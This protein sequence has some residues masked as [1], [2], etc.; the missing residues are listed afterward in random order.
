MKKLNI[1][2][3]L[4]VLYMYIHFCGSR[5]LNTVMCTYKW[6][7]ERT[8]G[9]NF[10]CISLPR[11]ALH[12]KRMKNTFVTRHLYSNISYI[13]SLF[14]SNHLCFLSSRCLLPWVPKWFLEGPEMTNNNNTYYLDKL[15]GSLARNGH[16][17]KYL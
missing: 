13:S 17:R 5:N 16:V 10:T 2:L 7:N 1:C 3:L 11:G 14:S 4:I 15:K 9:T 8:N 12:F 6:T